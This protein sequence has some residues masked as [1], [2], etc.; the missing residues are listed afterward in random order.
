MNISLTE[1]ELVNYVRTQVNNF[2]PDKYDF[3]GYDVNVSVSSALERCEEC[4]RF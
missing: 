4:F 3:S 2:F 1:R